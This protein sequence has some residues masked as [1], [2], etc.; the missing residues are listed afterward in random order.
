MC[1]LRFLDRST[2]EVFVRTIPEPLNPNVSTPS[3][4]HGQTLLLVATLDCSRFAFEQV[5]Q[6]VFPFSFILDTADGLCA[7]TLL[8]TRR[9]HCYFAWLEEFLR[10]M[11]VEAPRVR[12]VTADTAGVDG[13]CVG[14]EWRD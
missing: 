9:M 6:D 5:V 8:F 4:S 13:F 10:T 1:L 11:Q 2:C 3:C 14:S 12:L 7:S